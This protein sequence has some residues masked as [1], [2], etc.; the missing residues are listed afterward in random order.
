[1]RMIPKANP[2]PNTSPKYSIAAL[3]VDTM[4]RSCLVEFESCVLS[5][6]SPYDLPWTP[7]RSITTSSVPKSQQRSCHAQGNR[8]ISKQAQIHATSLPGRSPRTRRRASSRTRGFRQ[9]GWDSTLARKP[10]SGFGMPSHRLARWCGTV[11]WVCLS[12]SHFGGEPWR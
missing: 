12:S 10:S 1:V 7:S 6:H 5:G 11:L 2:A 9:A 8:L 4:S 3:R